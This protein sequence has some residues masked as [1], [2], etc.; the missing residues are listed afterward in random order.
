MNYG[1]GSFTEKKI[2]IL[3]HLR[4]IKQK[5][6]NYKIIDIG[7]GKEKHIKDK[8]DFIDAYVDF[9]KVESNNKNLKH[10]NG[11][12]NDFELWEEIFNDVE[13]N[14]KYDYCICTH[15]LEDIA[16]PEFVCKC[17]NKIAKAGLITFPS[18]YKELS[19][20]E[21]KSY[22]GY[23]HHRWIMTII[24]NTIYGF[25][26]QGF[27]ENI[28]WDNITNKLNKDNEELYILWK[29]KINFKIINDDWLGPS[30]KEIINIYIINLNNTDEDKI[31][32]SM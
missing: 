13:K 28:R 27:I 25:P 10:Y 1:L 19:Y 5:N 24:N 11:N 6:N 26:K 4:N 9:R 3:N 7:G 20:F 12:I 29:N 16:F 31:V 30:S 15:L 21:S 22:R 14:G 8:F 32:Y 18:K 2:E 23:S 17:I